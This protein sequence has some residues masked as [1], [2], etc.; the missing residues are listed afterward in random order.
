LLQL[1][2]F[3][4]QIAINRSEAFR[5]GNS[6]SC[7]TASSIEG[8][9]HSKE[10]GSRTCRT[11]EVI[12][13]ALGRV[14]RIIHVLRRSEGNLEFGQSGVAPIP[15][16][17]GTRNLILAR[18]ESDIVMMKFLRWDGGTGPWAISTRH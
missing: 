6:R 14:M 13:A 7:A 3:G 15:W 5:N 12:V 4:L 8:S 18:A 9:L 2:K 11:W 17:T 1:W 16:N 10:G